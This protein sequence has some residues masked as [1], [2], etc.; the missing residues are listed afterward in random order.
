MSTSS[1]KSPAISVKEG[2]TVKFIPRDASA[3]A[4]P[5]P[6]YD[7]YTSLYGKV[8][9]IYDDGTAAVIIDQASMPDDARER[10]EKSERDMR[11]KWMRSLSEDDR[12]KLTDAQKRF[13]LRYTLLVTATD[14]IDIDAVAPL[15]IVK[16]SAARKEAKAAAPATEASKAATP[17]N[18]AAAETAQL[19]EINRRAKQG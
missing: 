15:P 19:A 14:L 13:A 3:E 17:E 8:A 12:S 4:R 10:H 9:K 6:Y 16:E 11:D 5:V 18:S 7:F 2:Q 1:T